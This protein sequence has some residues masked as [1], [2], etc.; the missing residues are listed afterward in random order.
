MQFLQQSPDGPIVRNGIRHGHNGVEPEH[1]VC[2]AAHDASPVRP[3]MVSMLHII[4]ACRVG[5]PDVDL[6]AFD[7]LAG[8]V[9]ERAEY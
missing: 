9:L 1:A 4:V 7:G 8:R 6:A 3:V 2:V 5:F